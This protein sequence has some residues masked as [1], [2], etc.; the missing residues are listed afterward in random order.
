MTGKK[1]KRCPACNKVN[2][3]EA[4]Y[5]VDFDCNEAIFTVEAVIAADS[6]EPDAP[7]QKTSAD[8]EAAASKCTCGSVLALG[9]TKCV[10]CDRAVSSQTEGHTFTIVWPWQ[11]AVVV[12]EHLFIGRVPPAPKDLAVRLEQEYPNVS[13]AHAELRTEE[14]RPTVRDLGSLN[15]TFINDS[16]LS[17]HETRALRSNDRVR[18]GATLEVV[19]SQKSR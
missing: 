4:D 16:R 2:S 3:E 7:E 8:P 14:G 10:Y 1:T 5:C 6:D 19:I 17:P 9:T 15:G 13:R 11:E 18:F 12:K